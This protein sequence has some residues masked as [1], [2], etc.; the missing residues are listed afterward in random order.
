MIGNR[1]ILHKSKMKKPSLFLISFLAVSTY[2][3]ISG[4]VAGSG[5]VTTDPIGYT[6]MIEQLA[7]M[8]EQID[9]AK[10]QVSKITD[11]QKRVEGVK[12][13]LEG[14]Y[15]R[16][17]GIASSIKQ[18]QIDIQ[19]R[20]TGLQDEAKFWEKMLSNA[21]VGLRNTK[22][23]IDVTAAELHL[24]QT[25]KD[26]R[27]YKA[28]K[29]RKIV[30]NFDREYAVRQTSL[31]STILK[32]EKIIEKMPKKLKSIS[33]LTAQIDKTANI[34][35]AQ[36]LTNAILV[37]TLEAIHE[38]MDLVAYQAES[39]ALLTFTGVDD[40]V[41]AERQRAKSKKRD[42]ND[43]NWMQIESEKR[44]INTKKGEMTDKDIQKAAVGGWGSME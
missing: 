7:A 30:K 36:D 35:D 44:G 14:H 42:P 29:G 27:S 6:Y 4:N 3:L 34:K 15:N 20:P 28:K 21:K 11:V 24:Q 1:N 12:K 41:T 8:E 38:I 22:G 10:Q 33:D 16:A 31:K 32:S 5:M 2:F 19:N 43:R 39:S 23:A 40:D 26:P 18:A 17:V 37:K 13:Q 9:K 25:F